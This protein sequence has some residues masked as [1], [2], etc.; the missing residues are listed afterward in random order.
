[1]AEAIEAKPGPHYLL[2]TVMPG[3]QLSVA[4]PH[5][6]S[7]KRRFPDLTVVWG[8]YFPSMHAEVTLRSGYVDYVVQGQG[9]YTLVELLD[10]LERGGALSKVAGIW[11]RDGETMHR[12]H[13]RPLTDPNTLPRF[14]YHRLPMERYLG[15]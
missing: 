7:L 11:Y 8:G 6:R 12:T 13:P 2:C 1:I 14:P 4:V 10:T 15:R 9:E 3:P 5:T